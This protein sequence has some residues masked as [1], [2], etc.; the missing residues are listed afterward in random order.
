M[1]SHTITVTI[2]LTDGGGASGSGSFSVVSGPRVFALAFSNVDGV[3]GYDAANDVLIAKLVD[4]NGD[5]LVD[6]GDTV[7]TDRYP[8]DFSVTSFG[9]FGVTSHVVAN[10]AAATG[11][12][13]SVTDASGRSYIIEARE[14]AQRYL[15]S[16]STGSTFQTSIF[17]SIGGADL[18]VAQSSS[19]SQP[20][21]VVPRQIGGSAAD[22]AFID[23]VM[24]MP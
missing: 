19:P 1:A 20:G 18:I 6:A 11:T 2:R 22:S 10:V 17:D 7:I 13:A 5:D 9:T 4:T 23:V 14:T 16:T 15:E 12:Q 3:S 24:N 21:T 8:L